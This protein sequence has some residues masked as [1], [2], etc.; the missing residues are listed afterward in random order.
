MG[1]ASTE[2]LEMRVIQFRSWGKRASFV[3]CGIVSLAW[4]SE[5]ARVKPEN[6]G[7]P[8]KTT[9]KNWVGGGPCNSELDRDLIGIWRRELAPFAT[10]VSGT[11]PFSGRI[12]R[13]ASPPGGSWPLDLG[14]PRR[15]GWRL[16]YTQHK[17]RQPT[18]SLGPRD[19]RA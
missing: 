19:H 1:V 17:H 2:G 5:V 7:R 16:S 8:R 4:E 14:I 15:R 10:H 18:E 12:P 6:S 3:T 9:S 11:S 13:T